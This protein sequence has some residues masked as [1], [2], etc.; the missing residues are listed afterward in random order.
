MMHRGFWI[1]VTGWVLA[2]LCVGWGG[3][4][5]EVLESARHIP[6][7]FQGDV[8]VVGGGT[9]AVAAAAA[10]ANQGARVFLAAPYPYLGDDMTATLQ[11]WLEPGEQPTTDLAKRVYDD[12]TP[13]MV[14]PDRLP[15]TYSASARSNRIHRDTDPPRLLTDGRWGNASRQ[16]VQYDENVEIVADLGKTRAI[17]EVRL[18]AYRRAATDSAGNPFDVSKMTVAISDDGQSWQTVG[19]VVNDQPFDPQLTLRLEV[20]KTTRWVKLQIEK[21]DSCQRMLLGEIEILAPRGT[22]AK[23]GTVRPRPPRPFHVKKTLDDALLAAGVTYLYGCLPTD[24]LRDESGQ[25]CG[26]VMANRA[27]RQA[28]IAKT[29]IDAT[30]SATVA[31]LAGAKFQPLAGP[32]RCRFVVIGGKAHEGD[33]WSYRQIEPSFSGEQGVYSIIEYTMTFDLAENSQSAWAAAEQ[34][35]RNRTYDPDQ[36]FTSDAFW[37]VPRDPVV[38]QA[39]WDRPLTSPGA[40]VPLGIFRPDG[41]Q[42]LYVL[43]G[44]ADVARRE[45]T[46]LCRP[47]GLMHWGERL[48]KHVASEAKELSIAGKPRLV[49]TVATTLAAEGDVGEVLEGVRPVESSATIDQSERSIPVLA[50]YDV[51]VIGGGTGGAPAGIAAARRGARTLVVEYLHGLGGVGT[52]GAIAGYYWG[53][54]VGFTATVMDGATRW[55]VEQKKQWYRQQLLEAGA[56]IWFGCIG[57]GVF[58]SEN[59]VKGA[60]VA[61]PWGRGVVLAHTVVDST[62]NSDIAAAAGAETMYTGPDEFGM[63]GTG[64]PGRRLGGSYNNTDFTIVDETDLVD[65]WHVLVY[66]K[67]K[68]PDAFDHGR[69]V[70]TRERRRIVGDFTIRLTDQI[71]QRTYP[72]S[73]V[74]TWSNFD[75]HGYTVDPYLLLEHPGKAGVGVYVPFRAMLPK[76]IE[77][78]IVTGLSISAERDAVPLIRMQ[79]DIQNGG[80]AAGTAASMAAEHNVPVRHIDVKYL[81]QHLVE[82]GNLPES[83]LT[84]EDSYPLPDDKI[85]EAVANLPEGRGGAVIMA[86]PERSLPLLK[87]AFHQADG[88]Q[89]YV[90]A[91][92]LAVLGDSEGLAVLEERVKS[93]EKWDE[94]WDYRGMG[95]FGAALSPLDVDIIAMG[96]TR[97]PAALPA[98]LEKLKL[99][100]ASSEFSHH[101]AVAL[102]LELIGDAAAA[103]P[104]AELLNKPGMRG[105]AH[106]DYDT[107]REHSVPGGTNAVI[108]R[109]ESLRELMIAR[110]LYRCGDWENLGRQILSEYARDLRGHL[111]RHAK[112]VLA[113]QPGTR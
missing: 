73:V 104:L 29:I 24:V 11:L 92:A 13:A 68:Y 77:G 72:D 66:S 4:G 102:A 38:G 83:V 60:V 78:V 50:E 33:D 25:L 101:R 9:G 42:R 62:G 94:G 110:A 91:K 22:L 19:T 3:R 10:A 23:D 71:N 93:V 107:A 70:D 6:V 45:A 31:R 47:V 103:R 98:I 109:R 96:R 63:Q 37:Y 18:R 2:T 90:Y 1:G 48:G 51:V 95:Q 108:E 20:E 7:A 75:T 40:D 76:G 35:A 61:T 64:L 67:E 84:D 44:H 74:R 113:D 16:S 69:L 79:A 88:E 100:D 21:P 12:P 43:S 86:F 65:T 46:R 85:A 82:I 97:N 105:Y 49:G 53:N 8:V 81:Q 26:I 80:Y 99:L 17:R 59:L 5:A 106:L 112:A 52:E 28:V 41:L 58:Q 56:D 111:A 55:N 39:H 36:Q 57:C 27:G 30:P 34:V 15:F 14:D 87:Q 32:Q 54:R 89:R